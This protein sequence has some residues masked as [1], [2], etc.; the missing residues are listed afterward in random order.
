MSGRWDA[1]VVGAGYGGATAAALLADAGLRVLLVDKNARAGGKALVAERAGARFD[2]WPIAG[3]PAQG[4][5]FGELAARIGL[6]PDRVV[7]TPEDTCE[8][9]HV[10]GGVRRSF[11]VPAAPVHD[12]LAVARMFERLSV[13]PEQLGGLFLMGLHA[14]CMSEADLDALDTTSA[15]EWLGRFRLPGALFSYTAALLNL[16]FVV[17]LDRLPASE[18]VRTLRS[19]HAG[20]AGRYHAGGFGR[21]AE[22]AARFVGRRGG[23]FVS[24]TRVAGIRVEGG[25]VAGVSTDRGD[26]D[27]DVVVSNAG[28]QPTVLG[29]VG[30][31]RFD[32][33][34]VERVRSLEPSWAFVGVRYHLDRPVIERPMTVAFSD[35]SWWDTERFERARAGRWPDEPLL[36]VTVPAL[37]DPAL[38]SREV[39][40]VALVGTLGSPDPT[41]PMNDEA[42]ARAE[43]FARRLWPE[44]PRHVRARHVFS[45]RDVSALSRDAVVPGQ[46]GECIGIGQLIGQC[47]RTKPSAR[48]PLPGLYFVGCDAGG[49]GC[50]THQAVE[51]GFAVARMVIED[52]GG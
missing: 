39:P 17:P 16:L 20:G 29:L 27:A 13:R 1:V 33:A 41:S 12:P 11:T 50:G 19:F 31:E 32:R 44:L 30:A 49:W 7:L 51:S 52:A 18:A 4:S 14:R 22:E 40:Q 9:V 35:A 34:Y 28:I 3:G 23:R 8:F 37:W 21:I 36:F 47:G 45:A 26:F 24:G 42:V 10:D 48:A 5:R 43:A 38:G 46:G 15:L 25:R 6:V 2:L